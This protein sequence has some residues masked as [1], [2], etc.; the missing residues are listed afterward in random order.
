MMRS[1]PPYPEVIAFRDRLIA[2]MQA[3]LKK[4][5][6]PADQV[7][8]VFAFTLGQLIAMQDQRRFTPEKVM[9]I[10]SANIE[11]GNRQA[12]ENLL[13]NTAGHG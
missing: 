9:E 13:S 10:V 12:F 7:L 8:A 6:L 2:S 5:D 1:V 11:A 4:K 3:E